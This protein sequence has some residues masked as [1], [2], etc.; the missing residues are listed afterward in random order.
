M[1][2]IEMLLNLL[3]MEWY[4]SEKDLI[5]WIKEYV[6]NLEPKEKE[7]IIMKYG[8]SRYELKVLIKKK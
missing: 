3:Y 7:E 1:N 4:Y 6:R 8:K 2:K 5:E